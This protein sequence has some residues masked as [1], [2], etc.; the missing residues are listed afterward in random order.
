MSKILKSKKNLVFISGY[1]K[2]PLFNSP[3]T[4]RI[5]KRRTFADNELMD[6]RLLPIATPP[7]LFGMSQKLEYGPYFRHLGGERVESPPNW[8]GYVET[9]LSETAENPESQLPKR[10]KLSFSIEAIIGIK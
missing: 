1:R 10:P 3:I 7:F 4:D 5:R 8:D 2:I 6:A 9:N